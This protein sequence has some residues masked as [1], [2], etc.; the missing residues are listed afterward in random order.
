VHDS[1]PV[2]RI[3]VV[4]MGSNLGDRQRTLRE[5]TEALGADPRLQL[6][7]QSTLRETAPVGGPPQGPYLNGA[8]LVLATLPPASLLDA[9]LAL[10]RQ[11]GRERRERWGPRTLDLDLLFSP[12]LLFAGPTLTLPHPRLHERRFALEP[13]LELVP[14]AIDP[15]SG[16]PYRTILEKL[17][18]A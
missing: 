12:G 18:P 3:F 4:G 1:A 15:G 8:A 14:W 13:L 17:P 16:V 11:A 9:L 10:E 6:L 5:A 2:P 7:A